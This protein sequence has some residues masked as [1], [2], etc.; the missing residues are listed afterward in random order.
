MHNKPGINFPLNLQTGNPGSALPSPIFS[1]M[2]LLQSYGTD[3]RQSNTLTSVTLKLLAA[4]MHIHNTSSLVAAVS[5]INLK[6]PKDLDESKLVLF[7]FTLIQRWPPMF[8][9]SIWL[10][11]VPTSSMN[12][13]YWGDF[14]RCLIRWPE[15]S[16]S[17]LTQLPDLLMK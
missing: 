4:K 6:Q 9:S 12:R 11:S 10:V 3:A 17:L 2:V 13:T 14:R 7:T 8:P 15:A 1:S 16:S 5:R